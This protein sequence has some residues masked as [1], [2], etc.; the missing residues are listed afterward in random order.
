MMGSYLNT[1]IGF[2]FWVMVAKYYTTHD[3]GLSTVIISTTNLIIAFSG[4]GLT[5]GLTKYLPGENDKEGMINT[6]ITLVSSVSVIISIIFILFTSV[7][8]PSLNFIHENIGLLITFIF[9]T[10]ILG[11]FTLQNYIFIALRSAK[12]SVM[13]S[14]LF[15]II[16]VVFP[17]LLISLG[18]FGIVF[19]WFIS[20]L[21]AVIVGIFFLRL[22]L[23]QS[24]NPLPNLKIKILWKII[25]FSFL[26]NIA[27]FLG[28]IPALLMPLIVAN[29]LGVD[30]AAYFF[31]SYSISAMLLTIPSAINTSLFTEGSHDT[32]NF[33][34]DVIKATK[35]SLLLL[36]PLIVFIFIFGSKLL[37]IF[38]R[39]Y[40]NNATVLLYLFSIS[41]IPNAI[42]LIYMTIMRVKTDLRPLIYINLVMASLI[43][44]ISYL[45]IP[46]LGL[47][48][49]GIAWISGWGITMLIVI[50]LVMR[51]GW[52]SILFNKEILKDIVKINKRF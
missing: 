14:M 42:A 9:L 35:L 40:S 46:K 19:S 3:V 39:E 32:N 50:L 47:I 13:Q 1:A 18:I 29:M 44:G 31:I 2:I 30:N 27:G 21:V 7:I 24:Y 43:V 26:N 5:F 33:N 41:T 51:K 20:S 11:T 52:F 23:K 34:L 10:F 6:C 15:N 28:S 38:G 45:I 48:G 22:L 16:K 25:S 4:I 17:I 36:I 49:V 37:L 8:C 12:F